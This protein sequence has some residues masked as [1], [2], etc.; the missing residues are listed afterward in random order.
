MKMFKCHNSDNKIYFV[1]E[2]DQ[3]TFNLTEFDGR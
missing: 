3:G 1:I 2:D